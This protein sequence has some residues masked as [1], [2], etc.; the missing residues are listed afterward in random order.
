MPVIL[1]KDVVGITGAVAP[2]HIADNGVNVGV[3]GIVIV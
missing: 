3:I 1:S 2:A